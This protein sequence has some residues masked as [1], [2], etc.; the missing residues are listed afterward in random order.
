MFDA[1]YSDLNEE[2]RRA[3][4]AIDGPVLVIAG[5]GSGKTEILSLRT[6]NILKKTDTLPSS[7]LCLTFTEAAASNMQKRLADIMGADA[8]KIAI[9]TFHSFGQS[10]INRYPD[11]FYKGFNFNPAD[12]LTQT[13]ILES[14]LES[15]P[16]DTPLRSYSEAHGY[17]YIGDIKGRINDLKT[18]GMSPDE[19]ES[20]IKANESYLK[21]ASPVLNDFFTNTPL[22]GKT[23]A[24]LS[25]I[26]HLI[27][28]LESIPGGSIKKEILKSLQNAYEEAVSIEK[29]TPMTKWKNSVSEKDSEGKFIFVDYRNI[30]NHFSLAEIYRRYCEKMHQEGYFDFSDMISDVSRA[31]EKHTD[32][33]YNLQEQYQYVLVDEF[34]DTNGA[35][36]RLL[37]QL[38]D[39][40]VHEGRPN[41]MAVGDDDQ[42]IYKFQGAN[43]ANILD[44]R[45]RFRDP[46]II[47][48]T[49][50]YRSTPE[51]LDL[52]RKIILKG[53]ERLENK[54]EK[55]TKELEA[56][57][58]NVK[59]GEIAEKEFF[60]RFHEFIWVSEGIKNRL[61]K[62]ES[63]SEI[64]VIA[65]THKILMEMAKYLDYKGIPVAY[66]RKKDLF[67][68]THITQ[69]ITMMRFVN[70]LN[71]IGQKEA[72][73]L[74]PDILSFEFFNIPR[75]DIWKI[76]IEAYSPSDKTNQKLWLEVMLAHS[77]EKIRKI[78]RFFIEL[79]GLSVNRTGEEII[80]M[81]TGVA[82]VKIEDDKFVCPYKEHYFGT[83]I[84]EKKRSEF[85]D[86]L[87]ALQSLVKS[88][89]DFEGGKKAL[90]L[91]DIVDF[92][93]LH[94]KHKVKLVYQTAFNTTENAVH[95]STP[96]KAKG[97][98]FET[99]YAVNCT[100]GAWCGR[101]RSVKVRFPANVRLMSESDNPDDKLRLF[102]VTLSRAKRNLYTTYH[103]YNEDGKGANK[104]RF[105]EDRDIEE[106]LSKPASIDLNLTD[107]KNAKDF[108]E[109]Q[110]SP[111]KY[112]SLNQQENALLR[113]VLENYRLS[114]T[115]L[116][117]FLDISRG[118]PQVFLEK[119]LLRFP[120]KLSFVLSFGNAMHQAVE[121]FYRE[122]KARGVLPTV[123]A[124]LRIYE[125]VL[126]G[127]RLNKKDFEHA[128]EKGRDYL[129]V[130]Y[131]NRKDSFDPS[132]LV[133][134]D[135]RHQNVMMDGV[136]LTGK[137]DKIK[138]IDKTEAHV[139]DLKTG[140]SLNRWDGSLKSLNYRD[141]L[142]FYKI[143]MENSRDYSNYRV[144]E[145]VMEFLAPT[146]GKTILLPHS[147]SDPEVEEMKKLISIVYKK[148]LNLDFPDVSGYPLDSYGSVSP[149]GVKQFRKDLLEGRV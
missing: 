95:L 31:M 27:N 28:N 136:K 23:E 112:G 83:D 50:N 80:D 135:F 129:K 111:I 108:Y 76:S 64:A 24:I 53:E 10:V 32:L 97:L 55:I 125:E 25:A 114:V 18:G 105:L 87:V 37:H 72:D 89:R 107:D 19:F 146:D 34:Q 63:P 132:D 15:M 78:A 119:N 93:D 49:K 121:K 42:S 54:Y 137:L 86:H 75:L 13:K 103:K 39:A 69:L 85:M 1:R 47:V 9:Q 26:P 40:D 71:K 36:M 6:L 99:V 68:Q 41:I 61:D 8:Y 113:D 82:P 4:D 67:E 139:F 94:E 120:Q 43:L 91:S 20:V 60:T 11:Y 12:D 30:E 141:Q 123:D 106:K 81:L 62:G 144:T 17:S 138:I 104:L 35:Q 115:H 33:K 79:A 16:H 131:E 7:I 38:L 56:A 130:Y 29:T 101:G 148:I 96:H 59:P 57:N 134:V 84:F 88:V 48:L 3:V 5:P 149:V 44:F 90:T 66:E 142:V 14:V 51:V 100:D 124:L 92:V 65:P 147:I 74:L 102:Y 143:L 58:K 110:V 2:Q 145:G 109:M 46:E 22:R 128:L 70:S 52:V 140:K 77:N 118:G 117:N 98:E 116:Q 21:E 122:F 126:P 127:H 73:H 45:E 133:E